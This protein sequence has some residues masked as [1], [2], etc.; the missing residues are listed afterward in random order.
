M[1]TF[2]SI[3]KWLPRLYSFFPY[4][5]ASRYALPPA[6]AFFEVTYRCNLRCDMCHYLEIIEDT[7]TNR[8][9][10]QELSTE[11]VKQAIN[12]LPGFSLITFTGGEAFMKADF[13]EILKHATRKHKVHVITNGTTLGES[14]V[15][16]LVSNRVK[17]WWGSGMF[18]IGV[19]LEGHEALHDKITQVPGS[20]RKTKEGLE[21]LIKARGKK[22][23]PLIHVTCVIGKDNVQDLV[24]LY[25]YVSGLGVEV[26]NF[27]VKNPATYNHHEGYDD[28]EQLRSPA[29]PVEEIAPKLLRD[30]LDQLEDKSK[31]TATQ[32]RFSPNYI[33][34][35]EI[36]RY[37]SN[38]S[39]YQDYRC[40]IPWTKTAISAYGD[41]F[42]CP[43][44]PMGSLQDNGGALPWQGE[45]AKQFRAL[46]KD[47]K[48]FPGCLGC[49][50]SEYAGSD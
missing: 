48:I 37:Y 49:C 16:F 23:F 31:S 50:Q 4:H 11:Q 3:Q 5:L 20:F 8:K 27:V 18:Y 40:L 17:R 14:T 47:E 34:T 41:T 2:K 29:P 10:Q 25:E 33:T 46:L 43:H 9:Y 36:V 35:N 42:S 15:E 19:S 39:S 12:S 45:K 6:H 26:M 44:I 30:V 32:L 1:M 24:P 22:K 28:A 13:L 21:R 7:E 38:K